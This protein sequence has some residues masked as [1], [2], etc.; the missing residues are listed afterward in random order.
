MSADKTIVIASHLAGEEGGCMIPVF[1]ERGFT[2]QI[3]RLYLGENI[4]SPSQYAG[5]VVLGGL[6]SVNHEKLSVGM[7]HGLDAIREAL[8]GEKPFLGICL[9][10]Q[11]LV[12]VAGGKVIDTAERLELGFRLTE[13]KLHTYVLTEEGKKDPLF[14]DLPDSISPIL[15]FHQATVDISAMNYP[16]TLLATNPDGIVPNQVIRVGKNA[17]GI[18]SHREVTPELLELWLSAYAAL[19]DIDNVTIRKD[20]YTFE[21]EYLVTS[22]KMFQNWL[23]II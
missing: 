19:W 12:K 7:Q 9:G 16:V 23:D 14:K 2:V 21:K 5:L 17:Y 11:M 8:E 1:K 10:M 6:E 22:K 18:Q 4:P 15:Q 13:D 20:Y 3:V